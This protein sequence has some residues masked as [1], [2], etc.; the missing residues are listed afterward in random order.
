MYPVVDDR[1]ELMIVAR[2]YQFGCSR[3]Q[4]PARGLLCLGAF[5]HH[6]HL[7]VILRKIPQWPVCNINMKVMNLFSF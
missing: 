2:K 6:R 4:N 1:R 3:N 7:E 5:I